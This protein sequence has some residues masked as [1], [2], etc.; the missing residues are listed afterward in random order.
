MVKIDDFLLVAF[1]SSKPRRTLNEFYVYFLM[2]H[3]S[4]TH[5]Y[6][7]NLYSEY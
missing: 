7:V 3:L 1:V 2:P 5:T 6:L 4:L